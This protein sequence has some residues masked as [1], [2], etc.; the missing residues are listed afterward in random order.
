MPARQRL[1]LRFVLMLALITGAIAASSSPSGGRL[2]G[3]DSDARPTG[4]RVFY[5][6]HSFHMFVPRQVEQIVPLAKIEGHKLVGTQGI[7]GSRIY[8]HW[9]LA[10]AKN[11]AKKA[12]I[13]GDVDVFTMAAH[14]TVPDRGI[15]KFTEL[16][17]KHNPNLHLLVQ[18]SW[19]PF[20]VASAEKRIRDNAQRDQMKIEDL[21]AAVDVWRTQ[22]EGQV[23]TLNVKHKRD[24]VKIVP[25]GDA[26]VQ[27]RAMV[28]AGKF[29]G[30]ESQAALFRDPIGHG[31]P[32]IQALASY[33]N[34]AAIYGQSPVGSVSP[35]RESMT[36]NTPS[37]KS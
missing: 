16:G 31:G 3:E 35:P 24:A 30:I 9:D 27:L 33:C 25:V 34:F 1:N 13:T 23:D 11:R 37:C 17:L 19:F 4:L 29:P 10:D 20:D 6:G 32:H 8:Q 18:A 15:T 36:R 22:L 28:V 14:L 21:Q 7:G 26:V 2:V 12:L 5:T